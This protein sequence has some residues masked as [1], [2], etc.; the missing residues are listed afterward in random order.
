RDNRDGRARGRGHAPRAVP[1]R[2]ASSAP[3]APRAGLPGGA[4]GGARRGSSPE[5]WAFCPD[6]DRRDGVVGLLRGARPGR[7]R[8]LSGRLT[9]SGPA[10]AFPVGKVRAALLADCF[11]K[12]LTLDPRVVLGPRVGEDAAVLDMGDRYLVATTDPI[13]FVTEDLGWYALV[14]NANDLAV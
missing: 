6:R 12:H 5:P 1:V 2:D 10:A 8:A 4:H 14:V 3:P 7:R 9:W 13:T 11:A